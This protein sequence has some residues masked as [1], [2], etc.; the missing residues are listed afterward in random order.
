ME[1]GSLRCDAN[2]SLRPAGATGLGTKVEVKNMNSFKSVR[3][4]LR[5]E[6][7]RQRRCLLEG[8]PILQETRGWDEER[9]VTISMRTKEETHDYRYFPEPDLVPLTLSREVIDLARAELPE[10]PCARKKRF[11]EE[12]GLPEYDAGVLTSARDFA[13]FFE[14]T[15]KLCGNP[16]TA[17]NWMMGE[18]RSR[19]KATDVPLAETRLTPPRLAEMISLIQKGTISGSIAKSLLEELLVSDE[20][21]QTIVLR[22]GWAQISGDEV[23]RPVILEILESNA[24][25]VDEYLSGKEKILGFLVGQVMKRTKG[26][27]NPG[28]INALMR[29]E[30]EKRRLTA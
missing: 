22:R 17:S 7:E 12:Y 3:S 19:L 13:D 23:L 11:I 15:A 18:V 28:A 4:A 21:P 26:T 1:E 8:A 16:K 6:E 29:E 2:I 5:Y 30:I 27:A 24:D 25:C 10:L 9:Q 14:E 20:A